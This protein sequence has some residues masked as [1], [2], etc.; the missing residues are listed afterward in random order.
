LTVKDGNEG[1]RRVT[2]IVVD[3]HQTGKVNAMSNRRKGRTF[4]GLFDYGQMLLEGGDPRQTAKIK[5]MTPLSS[6]LKGT[7]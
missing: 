2:Y 3:S 7:I 6:L 4:S 5:F 1:T